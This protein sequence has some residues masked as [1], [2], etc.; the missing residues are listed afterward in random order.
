M[1]ETQLRQKIV[2]IMQGWVGRK[3]ADGTHRAIIDIYNNGAKPLP[4]NYRVTYEDAWCATAV[5]AAV[6]QAGF[7]EIIPVECGCSRLVEL[8]KKMGCWQENDAHVPMPGDFVLYDWKDG[9]D[10]ATTDSKRNP[11]HIGIV[12]KVNGTSITVIEGNISDSV[13]RRTIK[14][15]GRYIRGYVVPDY[16]KLATEEDKPNVSTELKIGDVVSF[17][18]ETHYTNSYVTGKAKKCKPGLARVT[19]ISKGKP[20]PYHLIAVPGERSSVYGWVDTEF[21]ARQK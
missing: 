12:E 7:T 17:T 10:Y 6:I 9:K 14:V 3:E 20:H 19:A 4:C 16:A 8:A 15:N 21:I 2:A 18:G 5:S 1:T 13:G 11:G